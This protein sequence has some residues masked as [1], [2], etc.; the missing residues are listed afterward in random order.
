M[1]T[2]SFVAAE[3]TRT[4]EERIAPSGWDFCCFTHDLKKLVEVSGAT[5]GSGEALNQEVED[6]MIEKNQFAK[7]SDYTPKKGNRIV[8]TASLIYKRFDEAG[9]ANLIC[10]LNAMYKK[11][12][13]MYH[14]SK[15]TAFSNAT[16]NN[17]VRLKWIAE[18]VVVRMARGACVG[19]VSV[20]NVRKD[21]IPQA[22]IAFDLSKFM[23]E[24]FDFEDEHTSALKSWFQSPIRF[25]QVL[26]KN[27]TKGRKILMGFGASAKK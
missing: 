13:P 23:C 25:D 5:G 21:L 27:D 20:A 12:H 14:L 1:L 24:T 17:P 16:A 7:S 10:D 15:L 11:N 9:I 2:D 22:G 18:L 6:W 19:T 26:P 4:I 3:N 8:E